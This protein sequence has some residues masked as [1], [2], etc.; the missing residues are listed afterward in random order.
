MADD[1]SAEERKKQTGI[2]NKKS[3][4]LCSRRFFFKSYKPYN[5]LNLLSIIHIIFIVF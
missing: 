2:L 5:S 3:S 1:P 4:I